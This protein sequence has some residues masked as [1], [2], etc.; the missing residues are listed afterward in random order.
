MFRLR[1][2]KW[3]VPSARRPGIVGIY[4]NYLVYERLAPGILEQLEARNP[5]R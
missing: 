2:W 4:T 5:E 1:K 3:P